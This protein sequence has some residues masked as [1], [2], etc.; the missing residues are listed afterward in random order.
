MTMFDENKFNEA[1][2]NYYKF[3]TDHKYYY[4]E[5]R[6]NSKNALDCKIKLNRIA[7]LIP[8]I[9]EDIDKNLT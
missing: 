3:K 8:S 7:S 5:W 6:T 9:I 4:L 2:Q 1:L